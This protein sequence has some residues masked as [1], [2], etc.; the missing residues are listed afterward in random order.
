MDLAITS[1]AL[2]LPARL[3]NCNML[4]FARIDALE[5]IDWSETKQS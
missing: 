1:I 2:S 4:H 3:A 5:L